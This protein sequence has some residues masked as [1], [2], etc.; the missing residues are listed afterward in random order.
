MNLIKE[1]IDEHKITVTGNTVIDALKEVIKNDYHFQNELLNSLN[2]NKKYILL[3]T[4]RREN[5]GI[6][7]EQIFLSV[8][9]IMQTHD[10]E[11]IFPMHKNEEIRKLA[12]YFFENEPR[13]NLLDTLIYPDFVNLMNKVY[14]IM[15]DSGGIQEEAPS[16]HK[17]VVVLRDIT[18]RK[19]A[20]RAHTI[21]LAGVNKEEIIK[22]V[23]E[24]M[25]SKTEYFEMS[26][27]K[28]PYGDGYASIRIM[29]TL[30]SYA[31]D[32]KN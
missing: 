31:L 22:C 5:W 13:M 30:E 12:K 8:K 1:H 21:K 10:V 15:T 29:N 19:E 17:P 9:E 27:A 25:T 24:L 32:K 6:N 23:N 28:N 14:L 16:L 4:H 18:E 3:T 20:I 7:M 11:F 26:Q 2:Y